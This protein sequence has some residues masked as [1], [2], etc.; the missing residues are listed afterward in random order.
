MLRPGITFI[1]FYNF[2]N[3]LWYR[4]DGLDIEL[5]LLLFIKPKYKNDITFSQGY[6]AIMQYI[7]INVYKH[8]C[9]QSNVVK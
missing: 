8:L 3:I 9:K 4:V 5:M 6:K 7:F 1:T 2:I